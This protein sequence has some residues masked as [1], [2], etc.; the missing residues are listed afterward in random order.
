[1]AIDET[2]KPVITEIMC[3]ITMI[4]IVAQN[5]ASPT[6]IGSRKYMIT[7]RMV[8]MDG[9]NTPPKVPNLLTFA[10]QILL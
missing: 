2:L 3:A 10:I 4:P 8:K 5:P 7:P 1:V 9:V 6:I